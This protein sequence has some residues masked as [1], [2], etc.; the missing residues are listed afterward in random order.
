MTTN[1]K[2]TPKRKKKS[3]EK[4]IH[5]V[6]C[7]YFPDGRY[8]IGYSCKSSR[9]FEKYYGSSKLV[10]EYKGQLRK[11][12]IR[13]YESKNEAKFT[14]MLLQLQQMR[15]DKCLNDMIHIRLRMK[16]LQGYTSVHWTP[17]G[18]TRSFVPRYIR[19]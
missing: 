19:D 14:E 5:R 7:T 17:E 12:V 3:P 10:T 4:K 13:E 16:Y 6:Y 15:D 11:E 2:S 18:D 8:Y 9:L 1:T